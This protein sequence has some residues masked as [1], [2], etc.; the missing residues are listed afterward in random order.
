VGVERLL[1]FPAFQDHEF[2][3]RRRPLQ[4]I[5]T[6]D[7]RILAAR[8]GE[9]PQ[10]RRGLALRRRHDFD[11]GDHVDRRIVLRAR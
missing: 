7:T 1:V 8:G 6:D 10:Q 5:E 9:L 11:V 4:D 3:R 2:P